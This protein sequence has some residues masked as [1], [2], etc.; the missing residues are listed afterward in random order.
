M[1]NAKPDYCLPPK[2]HPTVRTKNNSLFPVHRIYCVGQNYAAHTRE[3]GGNPDRDPPVF[4]S[5]PADAVTQ[6]GNISYPPATGNLHH[7]V[8]LVIALGLGG[9]NIAVRDAMQCVFGYAVG[10]DLTRRDIQAQAKKR[11]GPWDMAKGFDQSAPISNII[12]AAE[13]G[14]IESAAIS[15]EV[16]GQKRQA[17][18]TGQMIW[19]VAEVISELSRYVTLQPGDLIFTGTPEGVGPLVRGNAVKASIVGLPELRF[20]LS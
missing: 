11:G 2:P 16:N 5:K 4:F 1:L 3:M 10:V 8:E 19:S 12:V 20:M 6:D 17:G 18:S 15:L 14:N 9:A 13:A 7:E